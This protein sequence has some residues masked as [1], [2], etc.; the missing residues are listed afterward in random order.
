MT[1]QNVTTIIIDAPIH[2]VWAALL[3]TG[4]PRP[5]L[6]DTVA[7]SDWQVGSRYQMRTTDGFLMID[8]DVI[9]VTEPTRIV[10]GFECHWDDEVEQEKGA[11]LTWELAEVADGTRLTAYLTNA[12]PATGA[13]SDESMTEIYTGLKRHLEDGSMH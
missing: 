2:T 4:E 7:T 5:W 12:G 10:L 8:G 9:E 11:T 6:Y 1:P 3:N 13:S